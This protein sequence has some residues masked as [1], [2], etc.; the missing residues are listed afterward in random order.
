MNSIE[1][2]TINAALKEM[3][4]GLKSLKDRLSEA[5]KN[6]EGYDSIYKAVKDIVSFESK[7]N[8]TSD[9]SENDSIFQRARQRFDLGYPPRKAKDTS[10]GDAINW[11]WIVECARKSDDRLSSSRA[12]VT[13]A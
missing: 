9:K 6:P 13:T 10:I 1:G 7:F 11:E 3:N 12:T 8:L 4:P 2:E 5:L